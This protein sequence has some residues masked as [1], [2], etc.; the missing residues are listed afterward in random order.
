MI[1]GFSKRIVKSSKGIAMT[2]YAFILVLVVLVA[3]GAVT[4]FGQATSGLYD[5]IAEYLG[6][7]IERG[8]TDVT[9]RVLEP[10]PENDTTPIASNPTDGSD[11]PANVSSPF[12]IAVD[13]SDTNAFE[14]GGDDD[15]WQ[16][17]VQATS[18]LQMILTGEDIG[19]GAAGLVNL[20][21]RDD[22]GAAL[23]SMDFGSTAAHV[24]NRVEPGMYFIDAQS[25]NSTS[26]GGYRLT[27]NEIFDVPYAIDMD[28]T[29]FSVGSVVREEIQLGDEGDSW[30]FIL[31]EEGDVA[32]TLFNGPSLNKEMDILDSGGSVL[33]ASNNSFGD[34]GGVV[35][36]LP[37]G[38]Y[39]A[40]IRSLSGTGAYEMRVRSVEDVP[41]QAAV[42]GG[43]TAP[44]VVIGDTVAGELFMGEDGDMYQ[45]AVAANGTPVTF[46]LSTPGYLGEIYLYDSNGT[47]VLDDDIS[48]SSGAPE[49]VTAV[50]NAGTYFVGVERRNASSMG[51]YT[52][53]SS[54][55]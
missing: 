43:A 27:V 17:S 18:E 13:T 42:V 52:L 35:T 32:F 15:W 4:R 44:T 38:L 9:Y 40:R 25:R 39:Y 24:V 46:A 51:P 50:L 23:T 8:Q 48:G 16:L 37:A 41:S 49:P 19:S 11:I 20:I 22:T 45:F 33:A 31:P 55:P 30:M 5:D 2:E 29:L 14:T 53:T 7:A 21:I 34:T 3:L 1:G 54:T 10:Y 28:N 26:I 36:D 6:Y 47:T 12:A